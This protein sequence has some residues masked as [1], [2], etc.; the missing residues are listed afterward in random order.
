MKELKKAI[1]INNQNLIYQ[2]AYKE[3]IC[4]SLDAINKEQIHLII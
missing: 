1:K 2:M 3:K 4:V